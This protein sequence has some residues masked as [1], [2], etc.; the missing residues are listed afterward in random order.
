M[1]LQLWLDSLVSE[2]DPLLCHMLKLPRARLFWL[3][4]LFLGL[5]GAAQDVLP[6]S[7]P[8]SLQGDLSAQ[9]VAG[10]DKFFTRELEQSLTGREQFWH[11]DFSSPAAYDHSVQTNRE[12]LRKIIGAV[13][14]RLPV[15][16]LE[17]VSS[18]ASPAKVAETD[19]FTVKV[20]ALA[21]L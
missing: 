20:G 6:G 10:I 2:D 21:G 18:T 12:R 9:M 4:P 8:L 14:E 7:Q 19:S 13:D 11:R 3:A 5:A 15:T 17:F 16:A 1:A